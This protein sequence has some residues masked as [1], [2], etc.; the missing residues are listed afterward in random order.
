MDSTV[1]QNDKQLGEQIAGV[2]ILTSRALDLAMYSE[3]FLF[4]ITK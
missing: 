2:F 3:R 4:I 1:L